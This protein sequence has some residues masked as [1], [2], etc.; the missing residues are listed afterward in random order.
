MDLTQAYGAAHFLLVFELFL[1]SLLSLYAAVSV[2]FLTAASPRSLFDGIV[3]RETVSRGFFALLLSLFFYSQWL[4]GGKEIVAVGIAMPGSLVTRSLEIETA[5]WLRRFLEPSIWLF[6]LCLL[7]ASFDARSR[8]ARNCYRIAAASL[9][10]QL[11]FEVVMLTSLGQEAKE[12]IGLPLRFFHL[13]L[14]QF[15]LLPLI[16]GAL[17]DRGEREYQSTFKSAKA[18]AVLLIGLFVPLTLLITRTAERIDGDSLPLK[19]GAHYYSWF[20]SNWLGGVIGQHTLPPIQPELGEY[21]SAD[22]NTF[23]QH[24]AWAKQA[25]IDF[26]VFD[27][28]P[29]RPWIGKRIYSH[30]VRNKRLEG[31]EFSILYESLDLK[32]AGD[33]TYRGEESNVIFMTE[34]R[35]QRL[36][37]HWEYLAKHYFAQENY[38]RINGK[39]VLYVYASR[40]LVGPVAKAIRDA[41]AHVLETTGQSLYIVGDEVFFNVLKYS[42]KHGLLLLAEGAPNW[43]RLSAFDALTSYNPYDSARTEHGGKEGAERFLRDVSE[44]YAHYKKVAT[45]VGIHF[46]PGVLPGYN[47]RG[48]RLEENHYVVPRELAN[49]TLF[50]EQ[51]LEHWAA[52][53]LD[54]KA[55]VLTVTS[56]NEWNEG[57]QIEPARVSAK[58]AKDSSATGEL[59]TEGETHWGYG[60]LFLNTLPEFLQRLKVTRR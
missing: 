26:F 24:V 13:L 42:N 34:E 17:L 4:S 46:I 25:G 47:D 57:T 33:T 14:G 3:E 5:I 9:L 22:A 58:T 50:F 21:H 36:R 16:L 18:F 48:V 6:I 20:P 12:V 41:R 38:L 55:P 59:Y 43:D 8:R 1:A 39:A 56:W 11:C 45:T 19:V 30:V 32:E 44:L 15:V 37:K 60:E 40:H 23:S 27:W 52:P 10:A 54:Q 28:W 2:L 35:S 7:V 53:F 51:S 29:K 31:M 49:G